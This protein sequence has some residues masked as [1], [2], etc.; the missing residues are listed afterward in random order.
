LVRTITASRILPGPRRRA[1]SDYYPI[2][3]TT[4]FFTIFNIQIFSLILPLLIVAVSGLCTIKYH[5]QILRFAIET[6]V[7]ALLPAIVL[8]SALWSIS[9]SVSLWYGFQL[10]VTILAGIIIGL[11]GSAQ[12]VIRGIFYAMIIVIVASIISGQTGPSAIGPVL[13]GVTGSKDAMGFV[14]LTL[15]A[16]GLG[17][18][19]DP[20]QPKSARL[21]TALFIPLGAIVAS[22]VQATTSALAV[23]AFGGM[24]LGIM[25]LK[26]FDK[27]VRWTLILLSV[28]ISFAAVIWI[29]NSGI[30]SEM[31]LSSL[32]KDQTLTGRTVLWAWADDWI[33]KAP[34]LG[35]GYKS[36]WLG[37]SG[38]STSLLWMFGLRDGRTFQFHNTYREILVDLGWVGL[39]TFLAAALTF[40]YCALRQAFSAPSGSSAFFASM[41]ILL[42]VRSPLE[43]IILVFYP[44]TV[45][46]YVCGTASIMAHLTKKRLA[47]ATKNYSLPSFSHGTPSIDGASASF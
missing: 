10:A 28:F 32:N 31:I 4:F 35:H 33:E 38:D 23:I 8:L 16:A 41:L 27:T 22:G 25:A 40:L 47:N 39:L 13:I 3:I 42:I 45:L 15:F 11:C 2:A 17:V 6:K 30:S 7:I 29:L 18:A 19:F 36:F 20:Q 14:G 26:P 44:Y 24:F 43:S 34:I 9:P 37:G 46:F 12:D 1:L 5:R 21:S